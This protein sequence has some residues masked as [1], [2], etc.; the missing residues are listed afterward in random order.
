M[1][2]FIS[3]LADVSTVWL[4]ILSFVLCLI[5]LGIVGGMVYGMYKL[6]GAL[7]PVLQR[8]QEAMAEIAEGTDTASRKVAT[9][10]VAASATASQVRGSL[11]SLS[12]I[13]GRR[14]V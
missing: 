7:P 1:A 2:E 8:G 14:K 3:T 6:L 11:R 10:F 13:L 9:P 12:K 5:P 4:I